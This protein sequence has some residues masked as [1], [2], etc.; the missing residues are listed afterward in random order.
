VAPKEVWRVE[1]LLC[2]D[3]EISKYNRAVSRQRLGKYV[4]V[5]TDTNATM[6]QQQMND[7]YM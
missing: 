7:V 4:S 3:R 6:V 1:P 5:A 2:I